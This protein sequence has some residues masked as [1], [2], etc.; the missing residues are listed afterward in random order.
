MSTLL[1]TH[2]ACLEPRPGAASSGTAR[3]LARGAGGARRPGVRRPGARRS[4]GSHPRGSPAG[5]SGNT[6]RRFSAAPGPRRHVDDRRRHVLSIGSGEA[7]LRAAGAVVAAV[8]AVVD[9]EADNAFCAVRP[10]GHHA[11][12]RHPAV[13]PVQQCRDRRAA[14]R[15]RCT[16]SPGSR[17]SISTSIT[18]TAR[19]RFWDRCRPVLRLDA[20]VSALSRHRRGAAR[21]GPGQHRQRAAARQSGG[22]EFRAPGRAHPA[23]ARR[24]APEL[25]FI[26]AG[27]D[28]HG[29]IRW[30]S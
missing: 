10:P 7:A 27:F 19:R 18:A 24:F 3:S 29:A 14:M 2:P 11:D 5:A 8:D 25:V 4:A 17:S 22:A 30:P 20:P 26:S 9:G 1:L 13:L 21:P 23:G 15:A 28:A 12:A 16:A 6:S